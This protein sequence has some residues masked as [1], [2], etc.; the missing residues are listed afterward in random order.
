M[1]MMELKG[2]KSLQSLDTLLAESK[3]KA[4]PTKENIISLS[5]DAL[6]PG[7]YQ[8][9]RDMDEHSLQ[10]LAASIRAQGIILPLIVRPLRDDHYEII[11]G[12]RRFRAAKLIGLESVPVLI[13]HISDETALAFALIE[14]IQRESLSAIDE[15]LAFFRLKND[16]AMTHDEIAKR[17]GRSRSAVTNLM[18][19]LSL[20]DEVK[21]FLHAKKLEMG[22]ARALLGLDAKGQLELANRIIEH[23][24]SVRDTEKL[25]QKMRHAPKAWSFNH[26]Q[27][28]RIDEWEK[29]LSALLSSK[30]KINLNE[31]GEGKV[32]INIHSSDEIEWLL[33]IIKQGQEYQA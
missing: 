25:V 20:C 24:L 22:H 29:I 31:Q 32:V 23:G 16:F 1:T 8:P 15:A 3:A 9:R 19:L 2:L 5:V 7:K 28:E 11:A 18:R 27:D 17:V 10:E 14:N 21:T 12:E 30:V 26:K 4:S 6:S 13:R 33:K